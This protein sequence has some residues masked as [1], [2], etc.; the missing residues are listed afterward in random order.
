MYEKYSKIPRYVIDSNLCSNSKLL[1]GEIILLCHKEGFCYASNEYLAKIFGE[2][3]STTSKKIKKLEKK[4]YIQIVYK[5]RGFQ[6]VARELRLAKMPTDHCQK[7]QSSIGE[8]A[9]GC[10]AYQ[11]GRKS[12]IGN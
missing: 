9:N 6:V 2:D 10:V 12:G 7:Y 11:S 4:K 3:T 1:Y 8:N 5:K